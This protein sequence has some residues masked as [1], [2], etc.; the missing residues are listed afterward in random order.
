MRQLLLTA[1]AQVGVP[2]NEC[3][4]RDWVAPLL[5][6]VPGLGPRKA[7]SVVKVPPPLCR[8]VAVR[9]G[10]PVTVYGHS[11]GVLGRATWCKPTPI[12]RY[13]SHHLL[14]GLQ[15][16]RVATL[17]C[18]VHAT[19]LQTLLTETGGAALWV[20][21]QAIKSIPEHADDDN[22]IPGQTIVSRDALRAS[23][24][25]EDIDPHDPT[26][27]A[28]ILTPQVFNNTAPFLRVM[29]T[30]DGD[31]EGNEDDNFHP[32]DDMRV[33]PRDE[34]ALDQ[35]AKVALDRDSDT[36]DDDYVLLATG[37]PDKVGSA[38]LRTV[39]LPSPVDPRHQRQDQWPQ[40]KRLE[41][42]VAS[43]E[44]QF[45]CASS[46]RVCGLIACR[47]KARVGRL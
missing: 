29:N 10:V 3:A 1:V 41:V 5:Q 46:C 7:H 15:L 30:L 23:E 36:A 2:V 4:Q 20:S 25:E 13:T 9:C 45:S 34:L 24:Q 21:M 19:C 14:P 8:N 38:W 17:P 47:L 12:N 27:Y 16:T 44:A 33:H 28:R 31:H 18:S 26:T 11:E 37:V 6:F 40:G 39:P 43:I 35:L 42:A 32:R 22:R